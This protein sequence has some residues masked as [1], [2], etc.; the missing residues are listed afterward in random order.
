MLLLYGKINEVLLRG[1]KLKQKL[2]LKI[3]VFLVVT[4]VAFWLS[5]CIHGDPIDQMLVPVTITYSTEW[6]TPPTPVMVE[7]DYKL[8]DED[9]PSLSAEHSQF[10]GWFIGETKITSG[11]VVKKDITLTA[12]WT[13]KT[14]S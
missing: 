9:L 1:K 8:R 2:V 10:E 12:K 11:Y 3:A 7:M 5:A 4:N 6:G 14:C 13:K